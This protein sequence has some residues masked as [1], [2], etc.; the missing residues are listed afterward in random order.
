MRELKKY[1]H[2]GRILNTHGT[3][4]EL[5]TEIWC[6]DLSD[7]LKM[8]TLFLDENGQKSVKVA[9]VRSAGR[10]VLVRFEGIENPEDAYRFKG[11]DIYVD[12]ECLNIPEDRCLTAD[13]YGLPVIDADSGKVYGEISDIIFNPANEIYVVKTED[14][15]RMI[16]AVPQFVVKKDIYDAVYVRPIRG[17]F[18]ED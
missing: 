4:G 1:I 17:M 3:R 13:L 16:P 8:K 12:R 7:F 15:V 5:K 14:G 6:D 9:S 18:D 2:Q 10:F 11:K